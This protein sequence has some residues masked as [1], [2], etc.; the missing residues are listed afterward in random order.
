MGAILAG[1]F[2]TSI[3]NT[4]GSRTDSKN[5][6]S[7]ARCVGHRNPNGVRGSGCCKQMFYFYLGI[8]IMIIK[9]VPAQDLGSIGDEAMGESL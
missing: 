1:V 7:A 4:R 6:I 8:C 2:E 3:F 5:P 9:A